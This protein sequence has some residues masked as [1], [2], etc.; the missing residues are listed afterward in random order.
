MFPSEFF[1]SINT[2]GFAVFS[3]VRLHPIAN[4]STAGSVSRNSFRM[5]GFYNESGWLGHFR[6]DDESLGRE[7]S[8]L[9]I[10]SHIQR[11]FAGVM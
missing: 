5:S 8:R 3:L 6:R 10:D 2:V 9:V 4:K 7:A 1:G 11:Q